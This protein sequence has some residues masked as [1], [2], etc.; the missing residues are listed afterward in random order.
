MM[1]TRHC[2][3]VKRLFATVVPLLLLAVSAVLAS[4]DEMVRRYD[5]TQVH[6]LQRVAPAY[7]VIA[8]QMHL[9]GVV[10]LDM[11]VDQDGSVGKADAISGNPILT[12]AATSAARRWKFSPIMEDGKPTQA[13]VRVAFKFVE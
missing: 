5:E 4:G 6:I 8:H 7:P 1:L 12:G 9:T 2:S 10:V 3:E 13:V 11:I